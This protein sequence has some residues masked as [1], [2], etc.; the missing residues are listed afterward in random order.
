MASIPLAIVLVAALVV[1]LAVIPGTFGFQGWPAS[2]GEQVTERHVH[3]LPRRVQVERAD[4]DHAKGLRRAVTESIK[5]GTAATRTRTAVASQPTN[6][7]NRSGVVSTPERPVSGPREG[8]GSGPGEPQTPSSPAPSSPASEPEQP[9]AAPQPGT[10]VA[11]VATPVLR[12]DAPTSEAPAAPAPVTPVLPSLPLP[13]C[14][15][16]GDEGDQGR[17]HR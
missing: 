11:E 12:E 7:G 9:A 3:E 1:P 16:D 4:S 13:D 2:R 5:A 15:S 10:A 17:D 14:D 8:A 6:P